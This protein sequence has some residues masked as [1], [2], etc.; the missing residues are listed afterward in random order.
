MEVYI[1][2]VPKRQERRDSVMQEFHGKDCFSTHIITPVN[3]S[4][5]RVSHWLSF[6]QLTQHANAEG[7]DCF[8]FCEDDHTFTEHFEEQSFLCLVE[9]A[10]QLK[11]DV[12]IGGVSWMATSVQV[13]D[14]LFWLDKFNGTQFVI[15]FSRFYDKILAS[16]W[17]ENNVVTDFH[18]SENSENIFVTFPFISIQKDFGYSDVTAFNNA[19]GYVTGLFDGTFKGLQILDKVRSFYHGLQ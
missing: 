17:N 6:L 1:L 9:E 3:H 11:A 8:V 5:P 14:G 13:S 18:I 2:N 16:N 10:S 19:K 7:L 4:I 15:I 12:L